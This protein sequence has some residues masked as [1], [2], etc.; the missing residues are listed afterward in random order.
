MKAEEHIKIAHQ[1]IAILIGKN[2]ETKKK[3]EELTQTSI[4]I[5]SKDGFVHIINI[6]STENPL[7]VWKARDIIKAIG[8]GFSPER[9]LQL[10]DEDAYLEIIDLATFFGR[11]S[12]AIK[13][14][15]GRIIGEAGKTRRIIEESTENVLSVYGNTVSIIG[16]IKTLKIAKKAVTMLIKGASHSTVYQFLYKKRREMKRDRANLWKIAPH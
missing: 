13:R 7:A 8:R 12:N 6:P 1:R 14:I 10:L 2:G 16:N 4:E 3:I 9:A 5:D 11:N 15:K